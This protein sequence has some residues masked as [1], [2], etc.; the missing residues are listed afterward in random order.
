VIVLDTSVVV[1]IL[2]EEPGFRMFDRILRRVETVLPATCLVELTMVMSG[3]LP[4]MTATDTDDWLLASH[5]SIQPI[6]PA[7]A[8]AARDAFLRYGKGRH[9][10]ALNFGD[11]FSYAVAKELNAPLLFKGD[12]FRKTDVRV[13]VEEVPPDD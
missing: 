5:T 3:R 8:Y 10:A 1:A 6:T 2:M 13:A 4:G 7:T 11:C 12:D 9:P